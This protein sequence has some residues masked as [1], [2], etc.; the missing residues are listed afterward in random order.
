MQYKKSELAWLK[1]L[2]S[3]LHELLNTYSFLAAERPSAIN[4]AVEAHKAGPKPRECK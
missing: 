1:Q 3:K 4:Q 2:M